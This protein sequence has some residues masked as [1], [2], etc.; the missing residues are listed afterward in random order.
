MEQADLDFVHPLSIV[1]SDLIEEF[2]SYRNFLVSN[3]KSKKKLN[4][5]FSFS[6]SLTWNW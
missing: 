1:A 3:R 2:G 4:T 5:E 6:T